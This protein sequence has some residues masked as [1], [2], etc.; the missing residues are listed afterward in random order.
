[1]IPMLVAP[2]LLAADFSRLGQQVELVKT[3]DYLHV[4]VMDGVFVPNISLGP[5]I[6]ASLRDKSDLF[7]DVHL[8]LI[9]PLSYI[10]VFRKAGADCITFH[11]ECEDDPNALLDAIE[12]SGAKAGIAIKPAT[13]AETLLP[14]VS[15]LHS[16]TIM[17]VEPGFGGQKFMEEP[18]QKI[19][20]LKEAAPD[21][22]IEIDGGVNRET[23]P[24]CKAA[25]AD[26]LVAG[27]AVFK[28]EDPAAEIAYLRT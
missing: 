27:T 9:K 26:I 19:A 7:F 23:L 1:M 12:K 10:D 6:A 24:L 21:L 3:A 25:G 11:I 16:V 14:Y 20:V 13:P 18:L 15:R 5:A 22:L 2:S 28:A 17:T 4:D 8:M